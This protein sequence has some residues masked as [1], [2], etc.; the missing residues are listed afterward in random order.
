VS[1][2]KTK[3]FERKARLRLLTIKFMGADEQVNE[4]LYP[5]A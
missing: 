1:I 3:T 2:G 4:I 5:P